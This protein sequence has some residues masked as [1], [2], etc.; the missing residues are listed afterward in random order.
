VDQSD[1]GYYWSLINTFSKYFAITVPFINCSLSIAD[2][3]ERGAIPITLSAYMSSLR[4][5][6][7]SNTKYE[8]KHLILKKTSVD[9]EKAPILH[10]ER[11]KMQADNNDSNGAN[12]QNKKNDP[13]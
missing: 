2:N 10:F 9:R 3:P 11:L 4:N 8:L 5:L 1:V 12:D 7:L 13:R 6:C